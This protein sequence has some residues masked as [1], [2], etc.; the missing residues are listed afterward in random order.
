MIACKYNQILRF[1]PLFHRD[2]REV[3]P[4]GGV[5]GGLLLAGG[6]D[7]AAA[8]D[9]KFKC[10]VAVGAVY[11]VEGGGYAVFLLGGFGI[12]EE[13]L[14]HVGFG[15]DAG[16]YDSGLLIAVAT[17]E[18]FLSGCHCLGHDSPLLRGRCREGNQCAGVATA[19]RRPE[20]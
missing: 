17:L 13:G 3:G 16:C 11:G 4:A 7:A 10:T 1:V 9:C 5:V 2:G 18:K 8:L 12:V 15:D 20:S 6:L 14:D 19:I